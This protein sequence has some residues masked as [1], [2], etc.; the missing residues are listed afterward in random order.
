MWARELPLIDMFTLYERCA[1]FHYCNHLPRFIENNVS[2]WTSRDILIASGNVESQTLPADAA[3]I[4]F[5]RINIYISRTHC[6]CKRD[7]LSD[8]S[9][10]LQKVL[11]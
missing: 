4:N 9:A 1:Y 2:W 3:Q 7:K 5:Q 11:N 8:I 10:L 6:L